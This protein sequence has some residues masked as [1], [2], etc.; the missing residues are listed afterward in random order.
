MNQY[1]F[2]TWK[3]AEVG[4]LS[5]SPVKGQIHLRNLNLLT[6]KPQPEVGTLRGSS[7]HRVSH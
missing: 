2:R 1:R 4:L 3:D 5:A 6:V 7:T